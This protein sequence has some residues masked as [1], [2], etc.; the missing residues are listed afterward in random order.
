MKLP[1]QLG[2]RVC[3]RP[4][5]VH[6]GARLVAVVELL[7]G[8]G[9]KRLLSHPGSYTSLAE[10]GQYS[11]DDLHESRKASQMGVAGKGGEE[12][13][14]RSRHLHR[15]QLHEASQGTTRAATRSAWRTLPRSALGC[16][17]RTNPRSGAP[18]A[19]RRSAASAA[20][21]SAVAPRAPGP[22][23]PAPVERSSAPAGRQAPGCSYSA[24]AAEP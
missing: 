18:P 9:A 22:G 5:Y 1:H 17:R 6:E 12:G 20:S 14:Q 16:E 13:Q 19:L 8:H 4:E 7:L 2:Q 23:W 15:R 24:W 3:L 11:G 10:A 21:S